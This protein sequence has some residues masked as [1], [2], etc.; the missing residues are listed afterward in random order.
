MGFSMKSR[1]IHQMLFCG[2]LLGVF[3]ISTP[4]PA[5]QPAAGAAAQEEAVAKPAASEVLNRLRL[6]NAR[7]SLGKSTFKGIDIARSVETAEK[8]QKPI[9]TILSCSDSRVPVEYIFDQGLGDLFI[10][11]VAGNVSDTDEIG[12]IEY[13]TEHLGTPL[14]VVLGHTKCGAVTAVVENSPVH[15]KIPQLVDNIGPAVQTAREK[16]PGLEGKDLI[17]KAIEANVFRSIEDILTG[18]EMVRE[19]VNEKKL[20]VEGALYDI[21]TREVHWLGAHPDQAKLLATSPKE[22][23]AGEGH[24]A[25]AATGGHAPAEEKKA[26]AGGHAAEPEKGDAAAHP[27][28]AA[29]PAKEEQKEEHKEGQAASH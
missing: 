5:A 16:N 10:V 7:F 11:R 19:L 3:S 28:E 2:A 8:G 24:A 15:G 12:S 21:K 1:T 26:A 25:P 22:E 29:A 9:A 27:E 23:K 20:R 13:G 18:S 4:V 6:G 14:L 17:P